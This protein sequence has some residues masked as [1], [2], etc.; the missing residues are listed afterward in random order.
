MKALFLRGSVPPKKDHPEKLHYDHISNCEDMWTQ[1]FDHFL[2]VTDSKGELLY[3]R[4]RR[5][6]R[7][8][9]FVERWVPLFRNYKPNFEPDVIICR[10]GFPYYDALVKKYPKAKKI[11]YGA[12]KR[13]FPVT[14]FTGYD[15]FIVDSEKQK[16]A[17]EKKGK[18]AELFIKPAAELF[19][20]HHVQKDYNI[21]FMA[22]GV[23]SRIKRH[24]LFLESFVGTNYRILNLGN[25]DPKIVELAKKLKINID[26]GGWSLRKNLPKQ[27]SRCEVGVCCSTNYDSCP[28][29]IPEYMAC[30]L[31]VVVTNNVNFWH[32]KYITPETGVLVDENKIEEGVRNVINKDIN[33]LDYYRK[34]LALPKAAE[35]LAS[36]VDSIL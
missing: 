20:P 19:K 1:L 13:Y 17:I 21:C 10:G 33:P 29:V 32:K 36:L 28:R 35:Y 31:P 24:K 25:K 2:Q 30:G 15:L 9:R 7:N 34:N 4:G 27:I 8:D 12:G 3:E 26:W 11:Y 14:N 22:N 18:R 5:N 23:Q 6:K 16:I